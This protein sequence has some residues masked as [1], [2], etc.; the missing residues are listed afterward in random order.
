MIQLR[1]TVEARCD[2]HRDGGPATDKCPG[3]CDE[4][5]DETDGLDEDQDGK[6]YCKRHRARP[7][8]L[9]LVR[10]PAGW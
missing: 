7:G 2:Y 6:V 9:K 8:A 1:C 10:A 5:D 3:V 4:C